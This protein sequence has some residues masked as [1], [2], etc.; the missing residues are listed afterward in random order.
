MTVKSHYPDVDMAK[1]KGGPDAENDLAVLELKVQDTALEVAD[2]LDY[3]G[4]E[5]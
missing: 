1:V 4:D 5:G 2:S 3:E